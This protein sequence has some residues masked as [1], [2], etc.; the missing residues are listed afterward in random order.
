MR[1]A[2][3]TAVVPSNF[4]APRK[5]RTSSFPTPTPT[6]AVSLID[7][8]KKALGSDGLNKLMDVHT[9]K[10]IQQYSEELEDITDLQSKVARL[11]ELRNAE[12]YLAESSEVRPGVYQL[13]ENHCPICDV[14]ETC[15]ELCQSEAQVMSAIFG[16][17]VRVERVE[18]IQQDDRRCVTTSPREVTRPRALFK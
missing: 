8:T 1:S 17:S 2:S 5:R 14:A 10:K 4:G 7:S 16:D 3:K 11:A 15:N 13:I 12:G 9:E 18:H 6:L